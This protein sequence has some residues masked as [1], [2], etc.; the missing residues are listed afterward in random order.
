MAEVA[1]FISTVA[2]QAIAAAGKGRLPKKLAACRAA[3]SG[4]AQNMRGTV[5]PGNEVLTRGVHT[6]P[7]CVFAGRYYFTQ[8]EE[9]V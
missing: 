8:N 6:M 9:A 7:P 4:L 3:V 2:D 5:V 1:V